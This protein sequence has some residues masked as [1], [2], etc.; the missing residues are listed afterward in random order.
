MRD[1]AI[2][3]RMID[4]STSPKLFCFHSK[5]A[6]FAPYENQRLYLQFDLLSKTGTL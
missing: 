6:I 4:C 1:E 3:R 2:A 5:S